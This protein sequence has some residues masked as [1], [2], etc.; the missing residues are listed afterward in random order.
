[1]STYTHTDIHH[2]Q[3]ETSS[4]F[5]ASLIAVEANNLIL[6]ANGGGEGKGI[7]RE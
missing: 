3:E 1:M 6:S 4:I 2:R 5:D 7:S